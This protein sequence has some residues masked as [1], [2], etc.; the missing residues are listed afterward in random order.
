M[1]VHGRRPSCL[2]TVA[3]A[4]LLPAPVSQGCRVHEQQAHAWINIYFVIPACLQLFAL[5]YFLFAPKG[6]DLVW[7]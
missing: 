4:Y 5:V 1:Q 2:H 3:R 6:E 7:G